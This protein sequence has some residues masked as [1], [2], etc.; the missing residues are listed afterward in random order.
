[1]SRLVDP[2]TS[3]LLDTGVAAVHVA[4]VYAA[5]GVR[6]L[7]GAHTADALMQRLG[8]YVVRHAER[9]LYEEDARRVH[10]MLAE[11]RAA[12]AVA[13][14]FERVGRRWE[15]EFL[16]VEVVPAGRERGSVCPAR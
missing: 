11:G 13:Y 8:E 12:D 9:M 5:D 14:Y 10:R 1:M 4:A 15:R 6:F 7:A 16:R 2:K 3:D